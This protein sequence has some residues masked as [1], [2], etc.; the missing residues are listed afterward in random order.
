MKRSKSLSHAFVQPA[1]DNIEE[2]IEE[3]LALFAD[4][5]VEFIIKMEE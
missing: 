4:L 2:Q 1:N 3:Q 5:L